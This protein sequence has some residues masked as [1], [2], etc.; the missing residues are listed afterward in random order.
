MEKTPIQQL[1]EHFIIT[2]GNI[3]GGTPFFAFLENVILKQ[4]DPN[5]IDARAKS[6]MLNYLGLGW[7]Y[8]KGREYSQKKFKQG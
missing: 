4:L 6:A 7:L 5:A 8:N 1:E 3:L 2:T